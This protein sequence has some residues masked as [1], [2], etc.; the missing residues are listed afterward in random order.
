MTE[1]PPSVPGVVTVTSTGGPATPAGAVATSVVAEVT[2]TAVACAVPKATV[3]PGT[4]AVPVTVTT[5]P[6]ISGPAPGLRPVTL[7]GP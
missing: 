4:N 5:V 2:V 6:P 3:A 7:G 1:V